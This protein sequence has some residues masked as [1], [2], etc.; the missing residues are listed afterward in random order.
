LGAAEQPTHLEPR[1]ARGIEETGTTH[2]L[3]RSLQLDREHAV[4]QQ[5]PVAEGSGHRLDDVFVPAEQIGGH[6]LVPRRDIPRVE[7]FAAVGRPSQ[8]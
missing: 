1:P 4:S 6:H 7:H 8:D 3:A 2:Q 5:L